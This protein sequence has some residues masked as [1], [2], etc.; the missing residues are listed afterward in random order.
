MT[1]M[2]CAEFED[3]ILDLVEHQLAVGERPA[4]EAHLEV[5]ADCGE[6]AREL[7]ALDAA[8]TR[9]LDA[10]VLP[11]DFD[12]RLWRRIEAESAPRPAADCVERKRQIEAEFAAQLRSLRAPAH[13]LPAILDGAAYAVLAVVAGLLLMRWAPELAALLPKSLPAGGRDWLLAGGST[14]VFLLVGV[15]AAFRRQLGQ[16]MGWR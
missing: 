1:L 10:P 11:A 3:R 13:W 2:P 6:F 16:A 12:A 4:V 5:C 15:G 7:T 14:G 9:E 8:L